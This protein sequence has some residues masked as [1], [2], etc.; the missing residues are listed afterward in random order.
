MDRLN[1]GQD[2]IHGLQ[3]TRHP[4]TGRIEWSYEIRLVIIHHRFKGL[5]YHSIAI[6]TG[7]P[8]STVAKIC[9]KYARTLKIANFDREG[10]PPQISIEDEMHVKE[11]MENYPTISVRRIVK[12]LKKLY[13]TEISKSAVHRLMQEI[14]EYFQYCKKRHKL[15]PILVRSSSSESESDDEDKSDSRKK[16]KGKKKGNPCCP[17]L[18][19]RT[20]IF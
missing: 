7:V 15:K 5:S 4:I 11:I 19:E 18:I 8:E 2:P 20:D 13:N 3:P 14:K 16:N 1:I 17:L 9:R 10:A 12:K 6:R